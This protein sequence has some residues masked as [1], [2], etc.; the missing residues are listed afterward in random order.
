MPFLIGNLW[1]AFDV[2][3]T[4]LGVLY[5]FFLIVAPLQ[6]RYSYAHFINVESDAHEMIWFAQCCTVIRC[7]SSMPV[8][9]PMY[10]TLRKVEQ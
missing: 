7:P 3:G 9:F 10:H 6:E 2:P 4:V 8:P 1:D 5:S